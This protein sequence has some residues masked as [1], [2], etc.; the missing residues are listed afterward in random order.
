MLYHRFSYF[1]C[2]NWYFENFNLFLDKE[3]FR[4]KKSRLSILILLILIGLWT[5]EDKSFASKRI[6]LDASHGISSMYGSP[7]VYFADMI[8]YLDLYGYTFEESSS[9]VL[10]VDLVDYCVLGI[11][12]TGAWYSPYEPVEIDKI[13]HYVYN[14]G[15]LLVLAENPSC[16]NENINPLTERFGVICGVENSEYYAFCP[17]ISTHPIFSGISGFYLA[18][19]GILSVTSPAEEIAWEYDLHIRPLMASS[20]V[21]EGKFLVIGDTNIFDNSRLWKGDHRFLCKNIFDW[22]CRPVPSPTPT[23]TVTPAT[24][25]VF[26]SFSFIF[27]PILIVNIILKFLKRLTQ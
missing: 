21:N 22:L 27:F 20:N 3:V 18:D 7:A 1:Y 4:M 17:Y 5:S 12:L 16:P 23:C 15:S 19:D 10:T 8:D 26:S 14:G 11:T 25:P 6:L 2:I 9:S 13:Y 24:I